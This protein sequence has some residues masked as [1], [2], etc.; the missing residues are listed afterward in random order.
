MRTYRAQLRLPKT[1][2][3]SSSFTASCEDFNN[4]LSYYFIGLIAAIQLHLRGF[5]VL[6]FWGFGV[7]GV[8][9]NNLDP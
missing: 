6:G 7:L 2:T 8:A 5:G 1:R 4:F 3:S 9:N